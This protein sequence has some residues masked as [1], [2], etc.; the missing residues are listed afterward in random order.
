MYIKCNNMYIEK[1]TFNGVR[2]LPKKMTS[3]DGI[4]WV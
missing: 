3:P 1:N 4:R 2:H